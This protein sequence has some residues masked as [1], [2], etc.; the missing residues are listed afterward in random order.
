MFV[1]GLKFNVDDGQIPALCYI[2]E[3]DRGVN[4]TILRLAVRKRSMFTIVVLSYVFTGKGQIY[5]VLIYRINLL[6]KKC[7]GCEKFYINTDGTPAV[8][9]K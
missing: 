8:K 2:N 5:I 9:A 1:L 7:T 4:K 3:I 6:H